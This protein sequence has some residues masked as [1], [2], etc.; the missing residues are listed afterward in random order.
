MKKLTLPLLLLTVLLLCSC[1]SSTKNKIESEKQ[2]I[3]KSIDSIQTEIIG[4]LNKLEHEIDS[5]FRGKDS[6]LVKY[7]QADH[8]NRSIACIDKFKNPL[9]DSSVQGEIDP[10]SIQS[11]IHMNQNEVTI[12]FSQFKMFCNENDSVIPAQY[13]NLVGFNF[14]VQERFGDAI[15]ESFIN[16]RELAAEYDVLCKIESE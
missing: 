3:K 8:L 1:G 13:D 6:L 5:T 11:T 10:F 12:S 7:R 15:N 16:M 14:N 4:R 2:S 9:G